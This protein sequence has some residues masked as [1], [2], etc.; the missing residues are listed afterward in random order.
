MG[1]V[2]MGASLPSNNVLRQLAQTLTA[3]G[4]HSTATALRLLARA[5]YTT[6]EQ[7]DAVS[8]WVLL[9][10]RGIGE[11]RLREVRQLTRT[12]W[13]PPSPQAMH[14]ANWF[15]S[16]AQFA[17]RYW[18]PETLA[19]LIRGSAPTTVDDGPIEKRLA[20]DV[21]SHAVRKA[22]HHCETEE[23]V[24]ALCQASHVPGSGLCQP[25]ESTSGVSIQTRARSNGQGNT[26]KPESS[27]AK[28]RRRR[29]GTNSERFAYSR[30]RRLEIVER[31]RA[32]RDR[33]EV[34]NKDRWARLSGNIS[35]RTLKRYELEFPETDAEV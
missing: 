17:L 13:Q 35:G 26:Q 25:I 6:L 29:A 12:D 11:I 5:G 4:H 7:V 20:I 34:E 14:A 9:S 28:P 24:Q 33:G 19:S 10:I 27:G 32:A 31:F 3:G 18:P 1:E 30:D 16:S 15:L 2:M 23:L 22:Q 8:D 21:L